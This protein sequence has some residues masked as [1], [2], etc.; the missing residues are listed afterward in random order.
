MT[1]IL[2]K[3]RDATAVVDDGWELEPI[4]AEYV[5]ILGKV[6]GILRRM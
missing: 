3:E 4:Y 6:V 1:V 2:S 5:Q